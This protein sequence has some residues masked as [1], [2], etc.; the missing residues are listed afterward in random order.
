MLK[1][2]LI[3][4]G[5]LGVPILFAFYILDNPASPLAHFLDSLPSDWGRSLF[6]IAIVG[7]GIYFIITHRNARKKQP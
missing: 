3:L 4:F 6:L 1:T 7:L 5:V 2:A